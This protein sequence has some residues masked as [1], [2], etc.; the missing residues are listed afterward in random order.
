MKKN[1]LF[2]CFFFA[3]T[4]VA[5]EPQTPAIQMD[6]LKHVKKQLSEAREK[7][8][9]VTSKKKDP[10]PK[11]P[12]EFNFSF[13][14]PSYLPEQKSN[15]FHPMQKSEQMALMFRSDIPESEKGKQMDR[16]NEMDRT[17]KHS[18]KK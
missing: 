7:G 2:L 1:I 10:R 16:L 6:Q 11:K 13:T 3:T 14:P 12:V 5:E 8:W 4:L 15:R 9:E 18:K 17:F